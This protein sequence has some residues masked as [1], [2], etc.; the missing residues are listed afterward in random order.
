MEFAPLH[1][2]PKY[3]Q[4][5]A[6]VLNE[7]WKRSLTARLHSLKKSCDTFP[8]CLVLLEK[9]KSDNW[10]VVGHSRLSKV[11]GQ[12]ANSCLVESVVVRKSHRGKGYG[13]IIMERTE[14]F[15]AS[16]GYK[17]MYLTTH[18]KQ[19]FYKHLGYEFC[20]PIISFDSSIVPEH[21][22]QKLLGNMNLSAGDATYTS[23]DGKPSSVVKA[24]NSGGNSDSAR[25]TAK[26]DLIHSDLQANSSSDQ[27]SPQFSN[28]SMNLNSSAVSPSAP[29]PPPP[30]AAPLPPP[31]P[32]VS[33]ALPVKKGDNV[34]DDKTV[35]RWDPK[36]VAWMKKTLT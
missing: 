11:Q 5:C 29:P 33:S 8:I 36:L 2:M 7:E 9:D 27:S 6:E 19:D 18:D 32:P 26:S 10:S 15:A 24:P 21:L 23:S 4:E 13:R 17:I 20:S 34:L 31:P 12:A 1:T 25:T 16:K 22:A 35:T 14:E 30:P 3:F 28:P